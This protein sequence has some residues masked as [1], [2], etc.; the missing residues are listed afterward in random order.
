MLEEPKKKKNCRMVSLMPQPCARPYVRIPLPLSHPQVV[1]HQPAPLPPTCLAPLLPPSG[2][3]SVP[4]ND[5]QA[6]PR[7]Q[8]HPHETRFHAPPQLLRTA[9]RRTIPSR[10]PCIAVD[11]RHRRDVAVSTAIATWRIGPTPTTRR[12]TAL[13]ALPSPCTTAILASSLSQESSFLTNAAC[14]SA[15]RH[16]DVV[17]VERELAPVDPGAEAEIAGQDEEEACEDAAYDGADVGA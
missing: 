7:I 11:S 8:Q 14:S 10:G 17:L 13:V 5:P 16:G 2:V 9:I 4:I 15:L 12:G 6:P 3:F 1:A